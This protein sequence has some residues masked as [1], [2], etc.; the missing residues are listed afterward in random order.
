MATQLVANCLTS[1][2]ALMPAPFVTGTLLATDPLA[3]THPSPSRE[4]TAP[5]TT[6]P[7]G[8]AP[9]S[10]IVPSACG[11]MGLPTKPKPTTTAVACAQSSTNDSLGRPMSLPLHSHSSVAPGT[12]TP[13]SDRLPVRVMEASPTS[14]SQP[15][16]STRPARLEA[17]SSLGSRAQPSGAAIQPYWTRPPRPASG[18][19]MYQFRLAALRAGELYTRS[20]PQ[21]YLSQWQTVAINPT[22]QDWQ[23]LLQREAAVIAG[24]QGRNRLTVVVGDSLALWLPSEALP[25]DRFWLNQS[26]SGETTA[27]MLRRLHYFA[28]THPDTI[29]LMAGINDLRQGATDAQ[30]VSNVH[31]ILTRLRQQ[32]PQAKIVLH[33]LLPTRLSSFAQR[34]HWPGQHLPGLPGQSTGRCFCGFTTHLHRCPRPTSPRIN[35]RW[36]TSQPPRLRRL[37]IRLS[38]VLVRGSRLPPS[39]FSTSGPDSP[40]NPPLTTHSYH[41]SLIYTKHNLSHTPS[42]VAVQDSATVQLSLEAWLDNPPPRT[43]WVNGTLQQKRNMTLKHSKVQRRL[44]TLWSIY[45]DAQGLGGEIYTEAPCRTKPQGRSPDVA[46]LTP[47]LLAH[48]GE[49]KVL[50]QSFPL[51]AEI[52]SPTDLA[53]EVIAKAY[54]YLEFGGEEVWLVYPDSGWIMVITAA[55]KQIFSGDEIATTQAIM[56]GFQIKVSDLLA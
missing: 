10:P 12:V 22:H 45:V 4:P 2:P 28:D 54:E 13:A 29:H 16:L 21:R 39:R 41:P 17:Q 32:H 53:E 25:R 6:V 8:L 18:S 49:A 20:S 24:A 37:A 15:P 31:Q 38:R 42:M 56:P 50:P 34:S 55:T 44:S 52:V 26:I 47:D 23:A 48:H 14:P 33:S 1:Q 3:S 27:H 5:E 51:C 11:E 19:Q 36:P 7:T 46:Y 43:E 30:V 9:I 40:A 35:H